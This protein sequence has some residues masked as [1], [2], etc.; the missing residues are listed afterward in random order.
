M[1]LFEF[2]AFTEKSAKQSG[3]RDVE[4]MYEAVHEDL[5]LQLA[6]FL[7][8]C[9]LGSPRSLFESKDGTESIVFLLSG[10]IMCCL[11]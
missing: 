6:A 3:Q 1:T 9:I 7:R 4:G 5:L 2:A 10:N 8:K 11:T